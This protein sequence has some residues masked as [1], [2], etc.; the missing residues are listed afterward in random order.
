MF[1]NF[2]IIV[3]GI[4][5][6]KFL[7]NVAHAS[8]PTASLYQNLFGGRLVGLGIQQK[9]L[10]QCFAAFASCSFY[11]HIA[12]GT[13]AV[14]L[15]YGILSYPLSDHLDSFRK[16]TNCNFYLLAKVSTEHFIYQVQS[17]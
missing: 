5:R 3:H 8:A 14:P 2:I 16:T 10:L 15:C 11:L 1:S 7:I 4:P 12:G 9:V 13:H 17:V 6:T